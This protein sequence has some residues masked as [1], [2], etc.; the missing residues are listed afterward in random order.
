MINKFP[1]K[2]T[3][4]KSLHE[5][6]VSFLDI[7]KVEYTKEN[8]EYTH[9]KIQQSWIELTDS[10]VTVDTC[11]N[12]L[13][14][15][16]IKRYGYWAKK[17]VGDMLPFDYQPGSSLLFYSD[18]IPN[19]EKLE[20]IIRSKSDQEFGGETIVEALD[21]LA[22]I[23]FDHKMVIDQLHKD[24]IEI[25]N[26]DEAKKWKSLKKNRQKAEFLRRF[27]LIR[28]M[29]L[30]TKTNE[31]LE[32]HYK[33]L[34]FARTIYS[35][36]TPPT[37]YDDRGRIYIRYGQPDA[38]QVEVMPVY[39]DVFNA[40]GVLVAGRSLETWVYRISGKQIVFNFVD[41]IW[42][43]S[44]AYLA[45]DI[46]PRS[47]ERG[48]IRR[49]I[50]FSEIMRTRVDLDVRFAAAF[51][52]VDGGGDIKIEEIE[53]L[54]DGFLREQTIEQTKIPVSVSNQ[55]DN[56][57][58]LH[59]SMKPALFMNS[60]NENTLALAYGFREE[61]VKLSK[62]GSES[63]Q[64]LI[65]HTV[66][67]DPNLN[68]LS[69]KENSIPIEPAKFGEKGE[70][71]H[72]I[73]FTTVHNIFYILADVS[74]PSG[75]QKGFEDY[76]IKNPP[77]SDQHLQLSSVIFA[78]EINPVSALNQSEKSSFLIRNNL[79]IKINPFSELRTKEPVSI[80][81]EIYN[82][83]KNVS[84]NTQYEIEYKVDPVKK[85][86]VMAFVSKLNP[87]GKGKGSI[88]IAYNQQGRKIHEYFSIKLDFSQL[89][90]GSYEMVVKVV[91][92]I[93]N[94]SKETKTS[95]TLKR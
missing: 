74:N 18:R 36:L 8:D 69:M 89:S 32:E 73:Q 52:K 29:S 93:S 26:D 86:G 64:E 95:F 37:R 58:E 19:I 49:R 75:K 16:A 34:Q 61:D 71:I 76:S 66:I 30:G 27:W 60:N 3:N 6:Y 62:A 91:D 47:M 41:K 56:I 78:Q 57:S 51:S 10:S 14:Q 90:N 82:L 25:V 23:N 33:R 70:L 83:Q 28:D 84:G 44:L 88:S 92:K 12:L 24:I 45:E 80:Y 17:R 21:E 38:K 9:E 67:R 53:I 46:L 15:H 81:F 87:F 4:G 13:Y 50:A 40:P 35:A 11:G 1:I 77:Y 85:K 7:L 65:I 43:Y 72:Q 68:D 55:F 5:R 59:F 2:V 54:F 39:Q 63:Q 22:F 79:A 31:R 94:D 20:K 48:S 42:G